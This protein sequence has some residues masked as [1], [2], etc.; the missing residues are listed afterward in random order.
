MEHGKKIRVAVLFGGRSAEHEVSLQSARNIIDALDKDKYDVI[1][2]GIDKKGR[3]LVED[4]SQFLL[5][6]EDPRLVSLNKGG[7]TVTLTSNEGCTELI[8]LDGSGP[9]QAVDVVFPVLH[10]TYGEDGTVQG[11]LKLAD[12]P[13]VGAGVLGSSVGMDKDVMKRLLRDGGLPIGDFVTVT[14]AKM[15]DPEAIVER[16]GLPC[17]VKPANL[18]SSVGIHKVNEVG[19]LAAAME[20]AFQYDHKVLVEE[21][22]PGREIECSVLGNEDPIAS[23]PGE[24]TPTHD[25]YSYDAKYIDEKGADLTIPAKLSEAEV[26]EVQDLAV[27]TFTT[28]N[29]EG[30][31]RVDCFLRPDGEFIVNEINTLPGFTRISMY[32]KLWEAT[33]MSCPDLL[34]RLIQLAL[35]RH[36]LDQSLKT[37]W[38]L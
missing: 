25:F 4:A 6:A 12:V 32:P 10:G 22:V 34:D 3:W 30:L 18:G 31:A 13:F 36:R 15:L 5:N 21:F 17:F 14:R 20:D 35:D 33:G 29:C 23:L 11:L 19:A 26:A 16:L 24:V 9:N 8:T 2:V 1:P 7:A 38:D 37:N 28:L 27:R